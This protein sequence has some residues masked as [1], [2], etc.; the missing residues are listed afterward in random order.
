MAHF[1]Y[2]A[3]TATGDRKEGVIEATDKSNA[4]AKLRKQ[5]LTATYLVAE[6]V[7]K[8]KSKGKSGGNQKKKEVGGFLSNYMY[9]DDNGALQLQLSQDLPT[10]KDLA[11][12]A[13]QFSIMIERSV[14]LVQTLTIL[15]EQQKS[16][17]F[18][19]ILIQTRN[20]VENGSTLSDGLGKHPKIFD[21]L[22]VALVRAG[23]ISGKLD[24]ILI[25]LVN[26][27]ERS[28]R[29][30][31][32]VK[33]A[34]IYPILIVTVSIAVVSLL[35]A[36]VVPKMAEQYTGSGKS[37]PALTQF[38]VDASDLFT[39][40]ILEILGTI[41]AAVVGLVYWI[42][43]PPG[44]AALDAFT[45]K[46]PLIGDVMKKIS[47]SRFCATMSTM[48]L[49]GVSILEALDICAESSGNK[50]IEAFV[51]R[52]RSQISQGR[53]FAEPLM[54]SDIFPSM[55]TSMVHVG[56]TTGNLDETLAKITEIYEEEVQNAIDTM[57]SMIEPIMIV[58][59]GGLVGFIVIAMYLPIF[60]M[61]SNFGD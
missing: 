7:S 19:N 41:I 27:I 35:L 22:F 53:T 59:I 36:F 23:E 14:P 26:Y 25:Q 6:K 20:D 1:R 16:R 21:T 43:T 42:K 24:V 49:A 52:V 60:D 39:S 10:T 33:R 11:V 34:M 5:K 61:A 54:E 13:K 31:S 40:N 15:A 32:Q 8:G 46:A 12:F 18:K 28:A 9:Y 50:V 38:V 17:A 57:T 37:L 45:L 3:K 55:V 29:L 2:K 56:E 44:R 4:R 47:I 51:I 30:K 58:V 48:L